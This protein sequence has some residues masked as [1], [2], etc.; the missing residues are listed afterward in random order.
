MSMKV[1]WDYD[2]PKGWKP[3]N[4]KEWEWFLVRQINYGEFQ[5]LKKEQ[6]RKHFAEIKKHLDPGKRAMLEEYLK[7]LE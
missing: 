6:I 7:T 3:K 4:D 1:N 2:L 5:G